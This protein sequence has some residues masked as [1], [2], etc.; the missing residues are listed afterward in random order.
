MDAPVPRTSGRSGPVETE[1]QDVCHNTSRSV[2]VG[3]L[4]KVQISG[5]AGPAGH[6]E[7]VQPRPAFITAEDAGTDSERRVTRWA[8]T[9][10]SDP[11]LLIVDVQTTGL[12]RAWAVQIGAVD[13]HGT[14]LFNEIIN[15]LA[16]ITPGA[17]ALHG[18]TEVQVAAA[19]T[20]GTL[21]PEL[22][23]LLSGRRCLA[24]NAAFDRRIITR[25]MHRCAGD[26]AKAWGDSWTWED[27]MRPYA[28]WTGLWSAHRRAYRFQPLGSLYD[29]V[30]NCQ[31]LLSMVH[32]LALGPPPT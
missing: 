25:E 20:F 10:L 31:R 5:I 17:A 19:P 7:E 13:R 12:D 2:G 14:I 23:R 29:A 22:S 1:P 16:A 28:T 11:R 15:P 21:L 27:A 26:A 32:Q 3:A 24:Y 6:S 30:A 4:V 8:R 9:L 18:I